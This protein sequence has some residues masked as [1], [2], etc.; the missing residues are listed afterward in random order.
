MNRAYFN[1]IVGLFLINLLTIGY[2]V[3]DDQP[4]ASLAASAANAIA[5][6][7]KTSDATNSSSN[8]K[9][10][11]TS[12]IDE[13]VDLPEPEATL[14]EFIMACMKGEEDSAKNMAIPHPEANILWEDIYP[15]GYYTEEELKKLEKYYIESARQFK[16]L[17][18][19]DSI[20]FGEVKERTI[21]PTEVNENRII[22][23]LPKKKAVFIFKKIMTFGKSIY[24]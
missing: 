11:T 1:R 2:S 24:R 19:G 7:Q 16:R 22:I 12:N 21:K 14:I 8:P 20:A 23:E 5:L 15:K 9:V 3:A 13:K 18:P 4:A 10:E 6:P 17:K